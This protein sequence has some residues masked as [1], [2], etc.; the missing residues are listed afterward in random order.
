MN[1]RRRF[2]LSP[3][4]GLRIAFG[5]GVMLVLLCLL[6]AGAWYALSDL[7]A[8]MTAFR[9]TAE[10]VERVSAIDSDMAAMQRRVR[11]Y[12]GSGDPQ[13]KDKIDTAY[14]TL[15]DEIN[16]AAARGGGAA[17]SAEAF[18]R[19]DAAADR[20]HQGFNRIVE[21]MRLRDVIVGEKLNPALKTMRDALATI[22]QSA[23]GSEDFENAYHAGVV[24]ER[25]STL[26]A[27]EVR[28]LIT[29]DAAHLE[30]IEAEVNATVADLYRASSDLVSK[31]N[32]PDQLAAAKAILLRLP[33]YE[34]SFRD[35]VAVVRE[36]DQKATDVLEKGGSDIAAQA[37]ALRDA[38]AKQE[39][40]LGVAMQAARDSSL[41][42]GLV[43]VLSGSRARPVSP[44]GSAASSRCRSTA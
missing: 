43:V 19:I 2:L 41:Q 4:I 7:G 11:E 32:D 13:A 35:M 25:V 3:G 23:S 42:V 8:R 40:R 34:T 22:N 12:L 17:E 28:F 26:Q 29:T 15:K 1:P 38:A 18:R 30:A 31:L 24:Q 9:A 27:E 6:A 44:G 10:D 20:Y 36:R 39:A 21:L 37:K 33:A 16:A 14:R 5:F